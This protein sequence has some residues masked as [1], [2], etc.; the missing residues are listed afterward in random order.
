MKDLEKVSYILKIKIYRDRSRRMLGLSQKIYIEE[1]LKKFS[2]KN[3][4]RR[5]LS[6]RYGITLSKKMCPSTPEEIERMSRILYASAIESLMYTM[7]C[8]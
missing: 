3:S 6:L 4:K 8:T 7:L 1:V 5:F 2:M